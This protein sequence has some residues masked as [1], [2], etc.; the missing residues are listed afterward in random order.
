MTELTFLVGNEHRVV[1]NPKKVGPNKEW[2][3]SH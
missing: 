2:E 3:N 1:K